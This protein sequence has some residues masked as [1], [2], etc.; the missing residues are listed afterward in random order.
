MQKGSWF[1]ATDIIVAKA[2]AMGAVVGVFVGFLRGLIEHKYG[3]IGQWIAAMA[4]AVLVGVLVSLAISEVDLPYTIKVAVACAAAFVA[5]DVLRALRAMGTMLGTD[6][7][8]AI[9]RVL[10]ALRG[11]GYGERFENGPRGKT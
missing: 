3:S 8:G 11:Q 1:Q 5:D 10:D 2:A 6:P 7:I 4:A 9:R